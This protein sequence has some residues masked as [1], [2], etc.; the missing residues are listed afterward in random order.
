MDEK[1]PSSEAR[2]DEIDLLDL[3]R[4]MGNSLVKGLSLA[5]RGIM[6]SV[7]FLLRHWLPFLLSG[8][9]G[10]GVSYLLKFSTAPSYYSDIVLRTNIGFASDIIGKVN[11]LH[12]YS[13]DQNLPRLGEA[14]RLTSDVIGNVSDIDAFW[15]IDNSNDGIPDLVDYKRKHNVYDTVNVRMPDRLDIRIKIK[16]P[17]YLENVRDALISFIN[18]DTLFRQRNQI[19]IRQNKELLSRIDYDITLLDSLQKVKY[20]EETRNIQ[21]KEGGQMVFLQNHNTQ[22]VIEDIYSLYSR[23]QL[24]ETDIDLYKD[25]TTVLSDFTVPA[26]RING[27]KY[28]AVRVVPVCFV[29]TLIILILIANRKN[30]NR[31]FEEY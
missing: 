4:K 26:R 29:L 27:G 23:K 11:T 18:T 12:V 31:I 3:F 24:L 19:R 13:K 6:V 9:I 21:P 28:Y 1:K 14:L 16:D 8:I 15:V 17:E 5:G 7:V 30:I 22:L 25:V 2:N 10:I 20:F